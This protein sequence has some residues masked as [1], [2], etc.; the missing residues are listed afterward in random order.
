MIGAECRVVDGDGTLTVDMT[1][2]DVQTL[3]EPCGVNGLYCI[4]AE[5]E[6]GCRNYEVRYICQRK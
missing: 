3:S 4:N 6:G 5:N 1:G 2:D